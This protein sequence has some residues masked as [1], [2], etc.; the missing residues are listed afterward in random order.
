LTGPQKPGQAALSG[1]PSLEVGAASPGW[2]QLKVIK[3]N[4]VAKVR[5]EA[6]D[7]VD[8]LP[9][10]GD[11]VNYLSVGGYNRNEPAFNYMKVGTTVLFIKNSQKD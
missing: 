8:L 6:V 7:I 3:T 1:S 5:N 4:N 11:G 9:E 10:C 2:L